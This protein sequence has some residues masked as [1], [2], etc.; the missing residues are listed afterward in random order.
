M[1][2]QLG[3]CSAYAV[4]TAENLKA[5]SLFSTLSQL[6]VI[7]EVILIDLFPQV[8]AYIAGPNDFPFK[9]YLF[10]LYP[11]MVLLNFV[12]GINHLSIF[13][14]AANLLQVTGLLIIF[15]NL[16]SGGLISPS[17]RPA[18]GDIQDF[19]L[20]FSTACFAFEGIGVVSVFLKLCLRFLKAFFPSRWCR[21]IPQW[22]D[23]KDSLQY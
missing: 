3:L 12:K 9:G 7:W 18:V 13:S 10:C 8:V 19:P 4:F 11:L 20:F 15:Y 22:Q 5:V 16:V 2:T 6:I 21:F 1:V 14:G 17:E 23:Q